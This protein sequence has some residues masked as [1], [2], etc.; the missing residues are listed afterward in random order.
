MACAGAVSPFLATKTPDMARKHYL[1]QSL[2]Q[3]NKLMPPDLDQLYVAAMQ[4]ATLQPPE[5]G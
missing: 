4:I 2:L 1:D 3:R 5:L